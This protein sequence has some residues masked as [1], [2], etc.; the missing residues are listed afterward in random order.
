ME[1]CSLAPMPHMVQRQE[2][3][4][5]RFYFWHSGAQTWTQTW[6]CDAIQR[7]SLEFLFASRPSSG[8]PAS[9]TWFRLTGRVFRYGGIFKAGS[10]PRVSASVQKRDPRWY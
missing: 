10:D 2:V 7:I 8:G 5:E 6:T 9:L 3:G 4:R 1:L